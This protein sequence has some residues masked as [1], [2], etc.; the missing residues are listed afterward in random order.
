MD[1]ATDSKRRN[2]FGVQIAG[3]LL[4]VVGTFL[5]WFSVDVSF[6]GFSSSESVTGI[7]TDDGKLAIGIGGV[8]LILAIFTW[9]A[10]GPTARRVL[11]GIT[12]LLAILSVVASIIDLTNDETGGVESFITGGGGEFDLSRGI[13]LYLVLAGGIV[14]L[15]GTVM[16]FMAG[17]PAA[18]PAGVPPM[19]PGA[20]PPA[21][22]TAP[23]AEPGWRATHVAPPGGLE[24]WSAPDPLSPQAGTLQA[25]VEVRL[26]ER[27]GGWA[28][29]VASNGWTGWVDAGRLAERA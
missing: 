19:V 3:V 7:N 21:P 12:V 10:K 14:A 1:Q 15:A 29:V 25:G 22:G 27:A 11:L 23:A 18:A 5:P 8:I 17:A 6:G 24:A 20:I 26:V 2:G 9:L 4:I 28:K 13:G 16:G